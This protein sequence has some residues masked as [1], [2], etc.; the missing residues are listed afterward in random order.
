MRK[1]FKGLFGF[2]KTQRE[3]NS[4]QGGKMDNEQFT[5]KQFQEQINKRI[6]IKISRI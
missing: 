6:N 2:K 1:Y 4:K 3:V 5:R